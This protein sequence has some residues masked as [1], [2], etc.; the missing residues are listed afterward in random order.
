MVEICKG[1]Y[2]TSWMPW[3][4]SVKL[5][6]LLRNRASII[7][8]ID[9]YIYSD[10]SNYLTSL[11]INKPIKISFRIKIFLIDKCNV[12]PKIATNLVMLTFP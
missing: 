7:S 1:F 9:N 12:N 8:V 6:K 3:L 5:I 11:F 2:K 10:A 4:K